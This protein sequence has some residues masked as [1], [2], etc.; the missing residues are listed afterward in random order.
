MCPPPSCLT[1]I[2]RRVWRAKSKMGRDAC[3]PSGCCVYAR[4]PAL[5]SGCSCPHISIV[6]LPLSAHLSLTPRHPLE[7]HVHQ[8][9]RIYPGLYK[10]DISAPPRNDALRF[11][12]ST[13]SH[14]YHTISISL[15]IPLVAVICLSGFRLFSPPPQ[16]IPY[17]SLY[18]FSVSFSVPFLFR[19]L[20]PFFSF[21]APVEECFCVWTISH[22][23]PNLTYLP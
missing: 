18:F 6:S 19:F 22:P 17:Q 8:K 5:P 21:Y 11:S 14:V 20:F 13:P 16:I 3:A 10:N 15:F 9:Q 2:P 23:R 1:I 7:Y 12:P 4:P